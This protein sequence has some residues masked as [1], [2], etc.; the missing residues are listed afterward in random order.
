MISVQIVFLDTN[1]IL[2][3]LENRNPEVRDIIAQLLPPHRKGKIRLATSV[4]NVAELIDKEFDIHFMSWCLNQR[5]SSDEVLNKRNR[6]EKLFEEISEKNRK[7]IEKRV[8]KFASKNEIGILS[9]SPEELQQD[10]Y[11]LIYR[12]K[13]QCQDALMIATALANK[14]TYFLSND[15]NLIRKTSELFDGYSLRDPILREAFRNNV[16][17]SI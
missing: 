9:I 15:S 17:E 11:E 10:I 8:N 2:D 14:V 3:Y 4:F 12:H 6:D 1:I 7:E 16:L 5:M 13:L